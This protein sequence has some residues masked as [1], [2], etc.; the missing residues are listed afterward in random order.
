MKKNVPIV[1]LLM[2]MLTGCSGD[3]GVPVNVDATTTR[4]A[5]QTEV[6]DVRVA[7][8]ELTSTTIS[9]TA[10]EAPPATVEP[11]AIPRP[12]QTPNPTETVQ[13][14]AS[15]T[16]LER[17]LPTPSDLPEGFNLQG[18]GDIDEATVP[19]DGYVRGQYRD[20]AVDESD[21]SDREL[22]LLQS[23]CVE[24]ASGAEAESA[25]S[26]D[27]RFRSAQADFVFEPIEVSQQIGNQVVVALIRV[28][29]TEQ[30]TIVGMWVRRD[31]IFCRFI[32][33]GQDV[34]PVDETVRSVQAIVEDVPL[35]SLQP[36]A[37]PTPSPPT[38]TP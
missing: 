16:A 32:G 1:L 14:E 37:D 21:V 12:T 31:E 25:L 29:S 2:L 38:P 22:I 18:E 35:S 27:H 3:S 20:F 7:Q 33:A 28:A 6:A 4:S 15:L 26:N 23:V 34:A 9:A 5:E 10:T 11:T 30:F 8:T 13:P 17:M 24:Y 36:A 19:P